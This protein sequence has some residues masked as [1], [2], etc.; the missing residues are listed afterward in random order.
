MVLVVGLLVAGLALLRGPAAPD[1]LPAPSLA[2]L[3]PGA[4]S[5]D[6]YARAA[7]VRLRVATQGVSAGSAADT[8]RTELASARALAAEAVRRDGSF[9]AL[10]GALAALDEAVRNDEADAARVALRV[11]LERCAP[12]LSQRR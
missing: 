1:R 8:V 6:D 11:A 5:G 7:C 9:A 3:A 10:S 12:D 2:S 4:S